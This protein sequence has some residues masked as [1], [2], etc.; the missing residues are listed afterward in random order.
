MSRKPVL[1][2]TD[3]AAMF[4]VRVCKNQPLT[5][6]NVKAA[7]ERIYYLAKAGLI[8]RHGQAKRGQALWDLHEL[9]A[10]Y[11]ASVTIVDNG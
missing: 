4:L 1:L 6:E 5:P 9:S 3:I 8:T 11:T 7:R 2:T 10:P